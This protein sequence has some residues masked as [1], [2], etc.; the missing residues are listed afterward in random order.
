ME[1]FKLNPVS[2]R[3][4]AQNLFSPL[5]GTLCI[6]LY[7]LCPETEAHIC[8]HSQIFYLSR[9][10]PQLLKR[11][12]AVAQFQARDTH[13]SLQLEVLTNQ[14]CISAFELKFSVSSRVYVKFQRQ[15]RHNTHI[16]FILDIT[17]LKRSGIT[18]LVNTFLHQLF[19][20]VPQLEGPA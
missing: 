18:V 2:I 4:T 10:S 14:I 5:L 9:Y 7:A 8:F 15:F 16:K 19:S 20:F 1:N 12:G 17:K 13:A 11:S 3:Y 6:Y